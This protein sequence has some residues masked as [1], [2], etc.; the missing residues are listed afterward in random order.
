M[1][2]S[3]SLTEITAEKAKKM[4]H[5]HPKAPDQR[6]LD[7]GKTLYQLDGLDFGRMLQKINES[8]P[9]ILFKVPGSKQWKNRMESSVWVPTH[10]VLYNTEDGSER[11]FYP[12][13][14]GK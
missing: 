8:G 11:T 13:K 2:S 9:F 4:V 3:W 10:F 1:S 14:D 6:L 12:E 7:Q 5:V